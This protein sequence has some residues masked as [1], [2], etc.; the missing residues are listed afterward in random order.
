M[1]DKGIWGWICCVAWVISALGA[2]NWGLLA[3][4]FDIFER[5]QML[6]NLRMPLLYIVGIAGV[7]SLIGW[8]QHVI[9]GCECA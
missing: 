7:I 3:L 2:I 1:M 9:K 4:K 8:I 6:S 5:L